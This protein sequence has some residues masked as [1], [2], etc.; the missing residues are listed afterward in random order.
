M[1]RKLILRSDAGMKSK[2]DLQKRLQERGVR[3]SIE[4][5]ILTELGLANSART[6]PHTEQPPTP[7][8]QAK[9]ESRQVVSQKSRPSSSDAPPPEAQPLSI[10]EQE[11][12]KL[13]PIYVESPRDL[14]ETFREMHPWF[15]G[16][17]AESNWLKREKCIEKL[18][19]IVQGNAPHDYTTLFLASI[20]TLL[21]GVLKTVNSLRTTVC[22]IGCHL[23]QDL[24]RVC[25]SGLDNMVEI[26]LQ[27]LVKLCG[28]TKK[29][30]AA[31]ANDTVNSIMANVSYHVRLLQHIHSA[32][33]DKNVQPRTY[34]SG[35]LKTVLTKPGSSKHIFE[36]SG[37]LD[38]IEK[39][40]KGGLNDGNPGVRENMRPVYWAF[41]R[42]WSD[43][44][45]T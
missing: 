19:R 24:A 14:E 4:T 26:L 45:E 8:P 12:S 6:V 35:W 34:A 32:S 42:V 3:K 21:D 43:R 40:V 27:N 31:K 18:R 22:T 2:H 7:A 44:S 11:A 37:G 28:N 20:K 17:E 29:I 9:K 15:E 10:A 5:H 25:G 13:A 33:Q 30:S 16:K 23:V 41:A 1:S 36:H 38:L 39:T